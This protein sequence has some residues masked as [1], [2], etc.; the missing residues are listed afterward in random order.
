MHARA[1]ACTL[2]FIEHSSEF[3]DALRE[4]SQGVPHN[5]SKRAFPSLAFPYCT[6]LHARWTVGHPINTI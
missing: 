4:G 3:A 5:Q 6:R 2:L 1:D